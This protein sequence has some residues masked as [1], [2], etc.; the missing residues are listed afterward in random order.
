MRMVLQI[1]GGRQVWRGKG[2]DREYIL[3]K[4]RESHRVHHTLIGQT[5][6]DARQKA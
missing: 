6:I 1:A 5:V 3:D 2:I 4:L